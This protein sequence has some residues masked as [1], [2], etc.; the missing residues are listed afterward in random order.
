MR[1]GG[2]K[3]GENVIVSNDL[4]PTYN[5]I[6]LDKKTIVSEKI[7]A[8]AL[9]AKP[10]DFF[11]LHFILINHDLREKLNI[12]ENTRNIVLKRIE[13]QDKRL[14]ESELKVFLPR[15]FWRIIDDLPTVLKRD[16]MSN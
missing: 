16:L 4:V 1:V 12:D 7:N 6:I 9:R 8:L 5:L 15:S 3:L 10:R 13:S 2:E 14:L 11:D